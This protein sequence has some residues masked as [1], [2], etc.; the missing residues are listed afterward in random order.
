MFVVDDKAR[1]QRVNI[2]HRSDLEA[3]ASAGL[4]EWTQIVVHP[5]DK[6]GAGGQVVAR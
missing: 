5:S 4:V 6:V 3:E 2:R 1:L